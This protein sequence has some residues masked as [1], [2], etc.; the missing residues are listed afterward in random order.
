M[1]GLPTGTRVWVA[2]GVTDLRKGMDGLSAMVQT[3]LDERPFSG[4]VFVFRG[5]RGGP[6]E[7][8]VVE[9]RWDELVRQAAR[10]WSLRVAAG[11]ERHGASDECTAVEVARRHRLATSEAHLATHCGS[12]TT[13]T[14][15]TLLTMRVLRA[16]VS[17]HRYS[18]AHGGCARSI[19]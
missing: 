18:R 3:V 15:V 10:A 11:H 19:T 13:V 6:G 9:R 14:T 4:D 8:T 2:D 1:I 12:V 17:S 7:A 5:K 16:L